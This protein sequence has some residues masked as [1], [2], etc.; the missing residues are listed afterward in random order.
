MRSFVVGVVALALSFVALAKGESVKKFGD[1]HVIISSNPMTD[2]RI[3][4]VGYLKAENIVYTT[5]DLIRIDYS[6]KGGV[7][8]YQY[9][10]GK[11]QA[12]EIETT[13]SDE[14]DEIRIPVLVSES[15]EQGALKVV[16]QTVLKAPISLDISLKGLKEAR[17]DMAR[18]CDLKPMRSIANGAPG[19]AAWQALPPNAEK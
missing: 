10:F 4:G 16:G 1:W 15:L 6:R 5:G 2:A 3:C 13:T 12:S 18:R 9:R 7:A 8:N 11:S 19:W 14:S 17:E